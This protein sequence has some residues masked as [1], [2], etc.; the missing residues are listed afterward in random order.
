MPKL[1]IE[2]YHSS[3]GEPRSFQLKAVEVGYP[4]GARAN[5]LKQAVVAMDSRIRALPLYEPI[6]LMGEWL[7]LVEQGARLPQ[8]SALLICRTQTEEQC[9][10]TVKTPI[11]MGQRDDSGK[12]DSR[13]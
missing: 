13:E 9:F 4:L 2:V 1:R 3:T 12:S 10:R 8:K 7:L 11:S 6:W 5:G